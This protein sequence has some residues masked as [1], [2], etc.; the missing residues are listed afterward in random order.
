MNWVDAV[1]I[2][3]FL[4]YLYQGF[5][6]GFIEQVMELVGFVVTIALSIWTYKAIGAWLVAHIGLQQPMAEPIAFF[7]ALFIFQGLYGLA[8]K[9]ALPLV[10]L[11]IRG[12]ITNRMAGLVPATLKFLIVAAIFTTLIVI[13]PPVPEQLKK[14][15][16]AS[17]LGSRFVNQSAS[18]E[19]YLNRIFGRD[20]KQSLTFLT[21]PAQTEEVIAPDGKVDL[22]FTTENVTID[23]VSE[24]KMLGLVNDER[25]KVGLKPLTWNEDL[26]KV[27]RA[28]SIDMFK[29]GYFSHTDPDGKSPF[30]R[31]SDAGIK[32]K[33]A[34]ENL[35]YAATVDLA[36]GGLMRSPGH[37][38][39]I[40][41]T[42]F[43]QVGIGVIDGGPYGKMFTQNFMN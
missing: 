17:A 27:A 13:L 25:V 35:A 41:E 42:N 12:A 23:N 32:Y 6:R 31:M 7:V 21:V 43:G 1:I 30:D 5:R 14:E 22:K 19:A 37:R 34:G 33:T 29:R 11:K 8:L 3:A 36:H 24:Q 26:A 18:V 28:H 4:F 10:P 2:L 39:N 40:L 20:I 9:L 16:S 38:A 15:I